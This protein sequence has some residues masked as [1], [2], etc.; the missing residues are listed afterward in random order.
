MFIFWIALCSLQ[1]HIVSGLGLGLSFS[2]IEHYKTILDTFE[3]KHIFTQ[4]QYSEKCFYDQD[5][6][7][8]GTLNF[9]NYHQFQRQPYVANGYIGARVPNL[10][11][12]FAYD[13]LSD[14]LDANEEDLKNGWPQFNKR[15]AGAFVAG[16]YNLQQKTTATN[17]PWLEQYGY[18][19][20]IS[21]IPQWSSLHVTSEDGTFVLD[22]SLSSNNWGAISDY[23]QIVSF[24]DGIVSTEFTWMN[25]LRLRLNVT[26]NKKHINVGSVS[27]EVYN[28][29]EQP[30]EITVTDVLDFET[31][32]NC[33]IH[34]FGSV[35]DGIF[36]VFSPINVNGVF[37][38]ITSR[39]IGPD[40]VTASNVDASSQ[41][42]V[43]NE[44]KLK[45]NSKET[46]LV[47]KIVGIVTT[48]LNPDKYKLAD[49][50]LAASTFAA[51]AKDPQ[52]LQ[53]DHHKAWEDCLGN[54]LDVTF[55]D[56]ALLT[57]A[58]RSSIY[59]LHSNARANAKGLTSA[60]GVAGLSSD[61]YG[62]QVFWDTDLWILSGILSFNPEISKSLLDYRKYT[63]NQAILNILSPS[64]PFTYSEGAI[65][66]WTSGR[67]G[68]CTAS[69]PCFDY[70]YHIN[71][72][73]A[74]SALNLY[75]NGAVGEDFLKEDIFP[76]V[77][78]AAKFYSSY[79]YFNETLKKY[80]SHNLTD[81]DEFAN[82]I[83]NG[84]YTNVAISNTVQWAAL[85][86]DHIG[87]EVPEIYR[88]I[89]GNMH[90]PTSPDN[91]Q[92]VLEYSG[93]PYFAAIKQADV[94]MMTYPLQHDY[95]S[96]EDAQINLDYYA[97]KQVNT[98]PAMTYP[99][100]S[101]VASA[102]LDSGCS[103]ESYLMKSV[104]PYLRAPFAQFLE[105]NHDNFAANGGTNPA[106]P[107]LT[108]HG[109][110]LQAIIQG[111]LGLRFT[112]EILGGKMERFLELNAH[113]LS[114]IPNGI[115]IPEIHYMN[116]TLKIE[117]R[118]NNLTVRNNGPNKYLASESH[119]LNI[120][121]TTQD[122]TIQR[123]YLTKNQSASFIIPSRKKLNPTSLTECGSAWFTNINLG[124]PGD[125]TLL[126][127]D[128]SNS[129]RWQAARAS[130]T[131]LLIDL[132]QK[133]SLRE[134]V[135]NWGT[136]PPK[137][138]RIHG[139]NDANALNPKLSLEVLTKLYFEEESEKGKLPQRDVFDKILDIPVEI[140]APFNLTDYMMVKPA[141]AQNITKFEFSP[142]ITTRFVLVEIEGIHDV[143]VDGG[144]EIYSI[145]FF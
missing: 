95:P 14:S 16:F 46:I 67:Y 29:T 17:F 56:D 79:V 73:I 134:G 31:S 131:K 88:Q 82:H 76:I 78:D 50:V 36:M 10:G 127:H 52:K 6:N 12:G 126:M 81:P 75:L 122:N 23:S 87:V 27:L 110:F 85:I 118:H 108:A 77:N 92:I 103:S 2:T 91:S 49:D 8:I 93:M 109:G 141:S 80:T 72:A 111:I 44:L 83:N 61:S 18:D 66:P 133:K 5:T 47:H 65:Y 3:N 123:I 55:P 64:N 43:T 1:F 129:T 121:V 116:Q 74:Y 57:L 69:G 112:Y 120:R 125:V 97:M 101:I 33:K 128:G 20:T 35:R 94:V 48:D 132:K 136:L 70:E 30:T 40:S 124:L 99:I 139:E 7:V 138:L 22:P 117:L 25:F 37:G 130:T 21:A 51:Y 145:D 106:F 13:L 84:A 89:P 98:G 60:L 142:E 115:V 114:I 135:I 42:K 119:G 58:A 15:F 4:L 41:L 62:G 86:A 102:I 26:A 32:N 9:V 105:Q 28:P 63:R 11:Q 100:F 54:S 90:I 34:S 104:Q 19:S 113:A 143:D 24:G 144:A 68:N 59:Q 39:L 96:T 38:A 53:D 71:A 140:S 107:F 137:R 45:I